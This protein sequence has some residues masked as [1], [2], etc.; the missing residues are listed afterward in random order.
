MKP[1]RF[2]PKAETEMINAAMW[3]EEQQDDLGKR[4][5]AAVQDCLNKIEINPHLFP[6]I[7]GDT[8]RSLTKTFPFGVI[9][10][11]KQDMIIVEAV[12]HLHRDPDCWKS[13]RFKQ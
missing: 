9:F 4:F 2:H 11:I 5:L 1:I 10:R 7:D 3:Y 8:R 13:R 6:D 12:M